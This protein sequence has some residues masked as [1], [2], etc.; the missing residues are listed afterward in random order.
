MDFYDFI[1]LNQEQQKVA[2]WEH[3]IFLAARFTWSSSVC[4]YSLG[5]FF[6][7]VEYQP[8]SNQLML[9]RAFTNNSYLEPYME[10]VDLSEVLK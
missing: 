9:V 4:L 10:K 3:G 6:V 5:K 1:W 8:E 2:V 7:E